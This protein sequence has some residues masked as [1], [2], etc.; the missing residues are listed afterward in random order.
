MEIDIL[1][2]LREVTAYRDFIKRKYFIRGFLCRY[3]KTVSEPTTTDDAEKTRPLLVENPEDS[4]A[5][6]E[7]QMALLHQTQTAPSEVRFLVQ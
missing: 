1:K 7:K 3:V 5:R 2:P 6:L 4:I